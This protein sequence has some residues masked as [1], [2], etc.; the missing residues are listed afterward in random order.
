MGVL[1]YE[2]MLPGSGPPV[3]SFR[4]GFFRGFLCWMFWSLKGRDC[5][6]LAFGPMGLLG[7]LFSQASESRFREFLS[8]E[9]GR[10]RVLAQICGCRIGCV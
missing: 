3:H 2:S 4:F 5:F 8:R 9:V 6:F 1:L 10:S 7:Y